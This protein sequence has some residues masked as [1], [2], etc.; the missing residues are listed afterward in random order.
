MTITL[1]PET[2]NLLRQKAEQDGTDINTTANVLLAE[3]LRWEAQ[4]RAETIEGIRRGDQ[5]A[6]EGRERPLS[7]F[8][9]EQRIKHGFAS[10]WPQET[11]EE[12]DRPN[13]A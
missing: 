11:H 9:A 2:A 13:A 10:T 6:A 5:A 1:I 7:A 4:E 3:I 12:E 8:I